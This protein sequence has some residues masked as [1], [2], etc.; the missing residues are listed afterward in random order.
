MR[1]T[2]LRIKRTFVVKLL[3]LTLIYNVVVQLGMYTITEEFILRVVS[4]SIY[5]IVCL[6][7]SLLEVYYL[8]QHTS[9]NNTLPLY[10]VSFLQVYYSQ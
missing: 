6:G 5:I 10:V 1:G 9:I 8:Q 4:I 3:I 7:V 2:I